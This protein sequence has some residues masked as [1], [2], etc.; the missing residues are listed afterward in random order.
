MTEKEAYQSF[1]GVAETNIN[2][3]LKQ[4][5]K[6]AIIESMLSSSNGKSARLI[7]G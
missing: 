7:I 6:G 3:T 1:P 2:K 4:K 5:H